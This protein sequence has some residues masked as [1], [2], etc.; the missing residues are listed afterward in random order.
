MTGIKTADYLIV[1]NSAGGI[2]AVEAIREKDK[3]GSILMVSDEPYPAYSRPLISEYL[4]QDLPLEKMLFRPADFYES[5]GIDFHQGV[6]V[7]G[8]DSE[9][10]IAEL[11]GGL[12]IAWRKLLLATGGIPV[13]PPINGIGRDNIF[14]FTTLDDTKAIDRFIRD[15]KRKVRVVVIG[16]GLIGVSAA[17]ALARRHG[18]VTIVEMKDRLLNTI[19][20][21]ETSAL[22]ETS[23]RESGIDVITGHTVGGLSNCSHEDSTDVILDDRRTIYCDM[24]VVAIGV[25]ARIELARDVGAGINKGIIVDRYMETS[26]PGVFACGDA[27]EAYDFITGKNS[28]IPIWPNAYTGGRVAGFNMAGTETCYQ[29]GT[30]MNS[31]KYFGLAITS[32]GIVVPPDDTCTVMVAAGQ[33]YRRQIVL[34]EGIVQGMLFYGDIERSGIVYNLMKNGVNVE[35]FSSELIADDFGLVSLPPEIWQEQLESLEEQPVPEITGNR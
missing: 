30:S 3:S 25:R 31:V 17:E 20:D 35:E 14:T 24:V 32:A 22:V 27:A 9:T 12:S 4:A 33:G 26:V 8:L 13:I 28:V 19:L 16:G 1:G 29:G 5:N 7:Y 23:L 18:T 10:R 34:R 6:K 2:G 21:E 11:D 15:Y